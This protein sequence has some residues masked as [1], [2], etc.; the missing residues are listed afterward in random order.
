VPSLEHAKNSGQSGVWNLMDL[1]Y[2]LHLKI[3]PKEE[4]GG[5]IRK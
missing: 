1:G 4:K 5:M 2:N 3:K